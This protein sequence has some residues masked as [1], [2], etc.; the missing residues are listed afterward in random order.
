M[1]GEIEIDALISRKESG[2]P[3]AFITTRKAIDG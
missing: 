3:M 2:I 1:D